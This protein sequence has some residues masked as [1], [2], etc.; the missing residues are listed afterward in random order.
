METE[1]EKR[2]ALRDTMNAIKEG[3]KAKNLSPL[4]PYDLQE[5][6]KSLI[7]LSSLQQSI[8]CIECSLPYKNYMELHP[9]EYDAV[10]LDD[11]I[12]GSI[13]KICKK[14]D[15]E[16]VFQTDPRGAAVSIFA[17]TAGNSWSNREFFGVP[18][19]ELDLIY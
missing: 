8:N 18:A 11:G 9:E 19:I 13:L 2:Q 6:A 14:L 7:A 15:L 12:R 1:K 17:G 3:R 5:I 10:S 4:D 16:V